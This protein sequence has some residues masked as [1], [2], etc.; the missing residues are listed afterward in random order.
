[1]PNVVGKS[2]REARLEIQSKGLIVQEEGWTASNDYPIG[3]VAK[4]YPEA[5]QEVPENTG[6]I[7]SISNGKKET[8]IIM[9]NLINLSLQA[10]RDTL[11]A[12][13]FNLQRL[14]VQREEQLNLL[15]DTVIEQYPDPGDPANTDDE[16]D[17]VVSSSQ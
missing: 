8:N 5:F 4:Q 10:A 13:N 2:L 9:P 14:K 12:Y 16:V 15:P 7:L 3:I 1:M 17:L 6:V 11:R